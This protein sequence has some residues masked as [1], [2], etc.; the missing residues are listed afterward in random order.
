MTEAKRRNSGLRMISVGMI[1]LFNPCINIIDVLPDIFGIMLILGGLRKYS[2]LLLEL[3]EA[4]K[5]FEKAAWVSL[6][7]FFAMFFSPSADDFTK[8]SLAIAVWLLEC[9]FIVPAMK[10]LFFGMDDLRIRL[11]DRGD[12]E[13]FSGAGIFSEIFMNARSALAILPL[14]VPL[15][16]EKK[17]EDI[18]S[19]GAVV[20]VDSAVRVMTVM[21]AVV[22]LVLGIVWLV[23]SLKCMRELRSDEEFV[24]FAQEKYNAEIAANTS[25]Q[26]KRSVRRFAAVSAAAIPFLCGVPFGGKP[27]IPEF[28]F[29]IITAVAIACAG[30]LF[31]AGKKKLYILCG[32]F[33]AVSAASMIFGCVYAEGFFGRLYPY[34]AEGFLTAFLPYA[35]AETV[36]M[37]LIIMIFSA[38]RQGICD[39]TEKCVGWSGDDVISG[40]QDAEIKKKLKR[41]ATA[42]FIFETIYA[43]ATVVSVVAAPFGDINTLFSMGWVLRLLL[44]IVMLVLCIWTG[45][46]IKNE[47]GK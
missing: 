4:K 3:Y 46:G 36:S 10:K 39:M 33:S 17:E 30:E 9:I 14:C 34:E 37:A 29:G 19:G 41:R 16:F 24:S 15:F 40:K 2:D 26:K 43:F 12:E 7:G 28:V 8:L 45:D 38:L 31:S 35:I 27:L 32:A 47:T 42:A 5:S 6:F 21:C 22:S 11:C 18:V 20:N 13:V 25:L 44:S 23:T 1:F